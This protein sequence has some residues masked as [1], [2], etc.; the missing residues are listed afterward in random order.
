MF[1][2]IRLIVGSI[3]LA[4]KTVRIIAVGQQAYLDVHPFFQQH[5]NSPDAGFDSG[6]VTVIEYSYIIGEAVYQSDLIGCKGCPRRGD[7]IFN[8]T[9]VHGYDIGISFYK[10][11]PVL[12]D[13]S[14]FGKVYTV[15]FLAFM[16]YFRFRRIYIF[17]LHIFGLC[18]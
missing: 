13:N 9:L 5:V 10:E 11:A 18:T 14:L 7:Y 4:C 16:V 6:S 8:T 15:E 17:H 1:I 2:D 3:M 12:A